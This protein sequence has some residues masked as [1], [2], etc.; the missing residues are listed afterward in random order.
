MRPGVASGFNACTLAVRLLAG[1]L[2]VATRDRTRERLSIENKEFVEN[3]E[4]IVIWFI[5]CTYPGLF[6]RCI[7]NR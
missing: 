6:T 7:S 3:E 5:G 4:N 1:T 2:I